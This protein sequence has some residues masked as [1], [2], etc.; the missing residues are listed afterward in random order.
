MNSMMSL[1]LSRPKPRASGTS[2]PVRTVR[3][4]LNKRE[5]A[6]AARIQ[7]SFN[8]KE[9]SS[10]QN[11]PSK[12]TSKLSSSTRP[13]VKDSAKHRRLKGKQKVKD[14]AELYGGK[15]T[16]VKLKM[17]KKAIK[18]RLKNKYKNKARPTNEPVSLASARTIPKVGLARMNL[19]VKP[20]LP[21]AAKN[22]RI[23]AKF[24]FKAKD[25]NKYAVDKRIPIQGCNIELLES[26]DTW[27][28]G[29]VASVE[30]ISGTRMYW[31]HVLYADGRVEQTTFP[32]PDSRLPEGEGITPTEGGFEGADQ[33]QVAIRKEGEVLLDEVRDEI[34]RLEADIHKNKISKIHENVTA[35]L[36][37]EIEAEDGV[38]SQLE[39]DVQKQVVDEKDADDEIKEESP[40]RTRRRKN[41][42]NN[43]FVDDEDGLLDGEREVG[44][45][46]VTP[47]WKDDDDENAGGD[48][49]Y[50]ASLKETKEQDSKTQVEVQVPSETLDRIAQINMELAQDEEDDDDNEADYGEE[51]RNMKLEVEAAKVAADTLDRIAQINREL[52]ME[53]DD[54]LNE[55]G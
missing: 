31:L 25:E 51:M 33:R 43:P 41:S 5:A 19:P 12:R 38:V 50:E 46:D 29:T 13:R 35:E 1:G 14:L 53:N 54:S 30:K 7:T 24:R 27:V 28:A 32:G 40:D 17:G 36:Q 23:P 2:A 6:P 39:A 8:S 10:S 45:G 37:G 16:K 18:S 11:V 48:A 22:K 21:L 47:E 42:T 4:N 26:E 15:K 44:F 9:L 55:D 34:E 52:T 3:S 20:R 49:S